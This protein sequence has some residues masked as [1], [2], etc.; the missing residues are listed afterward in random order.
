MNILYISHE[1]N[2]GGATRSLLGLIDQMQSKGH[3]I[4]VIV[5]KLEGEFYY[6]L[7]ARDNITVINGKYYSWM[8][9]STNLKSKIK[10]IV[11]Y[12]LNYVFIFN[13]IRHIKSYN[14]DVIHTNTTVIDIGARLSKLT[15]IPH[16][17]QIRE[18]GEEDHGLHFI[19]NKEKC[20]RYINRYSDKIILISNALYNKYKCIFDDKKTVVIYNGI[21]KDYMQER[22]DMSKQK[23][24]ILISG[25]LNEGK[26]QKEAIL[27]V[28]LLV[29]RGILNFELFIAGRGDDEYKN[30]LEDLISENDLENYVTILGYIDDIKNLR[31]NMDLE[32]VCSQNEAFGRVTIEAMMSMNPVIASDTGA[33]PEL[34]IN[35]YNGFLY[36]K[37]DHY[38]LMDKIAYF[39][40]NNKEIYRMGNNAYKY[41][42]LHFSAERNAD[43]IEL[44]YNSIVTNNRNE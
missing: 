4:F 33:N 44:V 27:A 31:K 30:D 15:K 35:K 17:W 2:L 23:L 18:F 41:S 36:S 11:K 43:E 16:V 8:S 25:S 1:I 21:S 28:S 9:K 7:K 39:L 6:Q 32:L 19:F 13:V 24:N 40:N 12:V 37:G 22:L 10:G 14:I 34:V 20:L 42:K 26:G 5:P 3:N 38:D 29:K